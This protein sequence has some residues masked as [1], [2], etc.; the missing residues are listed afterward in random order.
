[1]RTTASLAIGVTFFG[2]TVWAE[3]EV[4]A[5]PQ[6]S[7]SS[8]AIRAL[9]SY[10]AMPQRDRPALAEQ[11]FS[12]LPLTETDAVDARELLAQDRRATVRESRQQEMKTNKLSLNGH[13]MP[14]AWNRFGEMPAD[15]WSLY[16]SL[17]GGGGAPPR[18]N[19]RQWE[20]QKRLYQL[21]EGIYVA[22][23]AP[24]NTWNLWHQSHIDALLARLIENMV[25]FEQA[26][27]N[28]VY[29]MGYSAGG[30]GV[31]Q[32]APRMADRFA[33]A[34][35]M[36]GHPN[37]TSPLGLRNLPFALQVGQRDAAYNRNKVAGQWKEQLAQLRQRD[38]GGYEH[39]VKL[40][41]NKGHWMDG[42]DAVAIDWM[43]THT[44][45]PTPSKVV[46][47]QDDVTHDQFYWLAVDDKQAKPRAEIVAE[48]QGQTISLSTT[49]VDQLTVLVDD[50]FID[51]D[52]PVKI[53]CSGKVVHD[54]V[55]HRTIARLSETLNR[56]GDPY[57]SFPGAVT[58]SIPKPFPQS[59]IPDEAIPRYSA[60]RC[61][62]PPVIDGKLDEEAWTSADTTRSFVDLISGQATMHETR[63][64]ILWDDQ[65][66]YIG[67]WVA[68]PNVDAKYRNRDDPI[69]YDN[70][71]EVF[72]AG[73]DAYYE[74]EINAL[75]TVYEGMFVWQDAY[76]R[77][78]YSD[79]PQL[80][81][82][83]PQ[84]QTFDG[85]GFKHHPRGK[86]LAF[87]G[88]D[89]PNFKAAV[90]I[91]GTM[92]DPSDVDRGWTVE[93][94]FPWKEMKWLAKGDGRA[95]PPKPGD[96]WRIDLFRFNKYKAPADADSAT[97]VDSGG[98]AWGKH[99]V[100]DSHI[101]EIFPIV[102]FRDR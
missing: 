23:R 17:H 89:F 5:Q 51:L 55:V 34:A 63:A 7:A 95:L 36:A 49:D 2:L 15:G 6:V 18:V 94:A 26:N 92:N 59:L 39:F 72:I 75:E 16:I 88:Y 45:D 62:E 28:R 78:G 74:F 42:E 60:F 20:N 19:D 8:S 24:T 84:A 93:L 67:F 54:A 25:V 32:L 53:E 3:Q 85:V 91:D 43:A 83:H 77:G 11:D 79:D 71:V 73:K 97:A 64:A 22:P 52:Q 44:R 98:W 100:W 66:M 31:F 48:V 21:K 38:P 80:T 14:L 46:W 65:Y 102:T 27:P 101:P 4:P 81:R 40:H 41:P 12:S 30:D 70:D 61:L 90:H 96:R 87:L 1:M 9:R 99:G 47:K 58:V 82:D 50:R 56:R 86:R 68:E 35:M 69:Y 57:L 37:E 76:E 13:T 33:A 29:I 10:L